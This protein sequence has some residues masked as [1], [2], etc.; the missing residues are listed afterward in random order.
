L[1]TNS[2]A[3]LGHYAMGGKHG[4]L[5]PA[6]DAAKML[7]RQIN[8]IVGLIDQIVFRTW[9]VRPMHPRTHVEWD[10]L[11]GH[12]HRIENL[13]AMPGIKLIHDDPRS[14]ELV[15]KG[16][17]AEL[18]G[19]IAGVVA[20]EQDPVRIL[21]RSLGIPATTENLVRRAGLTELA[22]RVE[23]PT[24]VYRL[25]SPWENGYCESLSGRLRDERAKIARFTR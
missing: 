4:A 8:A 24:A 20:S 12:S 22:L 17:R 21:K 3:D 10:V 18:P 13:S 5:L 25:G 23:N 15:G 11:P 7:T 9:T 2:L 1:L 6:V 19:V 14:V 16:Q